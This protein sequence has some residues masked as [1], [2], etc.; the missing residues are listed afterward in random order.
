MKKRRVISIAVLLLF[1]DSALVSAERESQRGK[2][3]APIRT[4]AEKGDVNAQLELGRRYW[5]GD[6]IP[7]NQTEAAFWYRKAAEQGD[8]AAQY[9]L[10][11]RFE[12]GEGVAKDEAEATAWYLRAASQGHSSAKAEVAKRFGNESG[13]VATTELHRWLLKA[14]TL[15]I[16]TAQFRLAMMYLA[17]DGV[18]KDLGVA[19]EWFRK[20]AAETRTAAGAGDAEAQRSIAW[21]LAEGHGL[22][23]NLP[24]AVVWYRKASEQG[25]SESQI[26]LARMYESGNG[27]A[28]DPVE[29]FHWYNEAYDR[30]SSVAA[31]AVTRLLVSVRAA[32]QKGNARAQFYLGRNYL[33]GRGLA[34]DL[35]EGAKWISKAAVQGLV[36][37]QYAIGRC[38]AE[39]TGVPKDSVEA[40]VW[41]NRAAAAAN[42]D[43]IRLRDSLEQSMTRQQIADAQR[44]SVELKPRNLSRAPDSPGDDVPIASATGFFI[45]EDGFLVTNAHVVE[46]STQ[47]RLVTSGGTISAKV[48]KVDSANDL[49]LLKAEGKFAPLPIASSRAV[50]LGNS[51]AMVGFPNIGLQ[52]FAPKFARGEIASLSGAADDA[53]YFQISVPVQPGNSGGALVDERGNVVGVVAAKLSALAVL[54]SSGALPENVNYA[55]KSSFL[56]SFLESV[57][58]VSAKLKELNTKERK[59]EEV[60]KAAEQAAVLVLVY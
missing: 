59:F 50:R 34:K 43:A 14:A 19:E 58:E 32:A 39:G 24:E 29:A 52:G 35:I 48:V 17:G 54:K 56:L 46:D 27:V 40:Y 57:P 26:T 45:T 13:R 18:E 5:L 60:V 41:L 36:D 11:W 2:S 7:R 20:A 37:A 30:V 49:A 51:V 44:L 6:G 55:V 31:P 25:D 10:G 8:A 47:V 28:P 21:M 53:R 23:K 1:C 33:Q 16:A 12:K 3:I 38:Y 42:G 4:R 9:Q 22:E 15:G